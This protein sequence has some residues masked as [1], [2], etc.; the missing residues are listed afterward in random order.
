MENAI[1]GTV[2]E[3]NAYV[4][5]RKVTA[6]AI[7]IDHAIMNLVSVCLGGVPMCH[8]QGAWQATSDSAL[9]PEEPW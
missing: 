5:D 8:G 6:K 1:I 3:N 2:A 9:V 7:S 4:P